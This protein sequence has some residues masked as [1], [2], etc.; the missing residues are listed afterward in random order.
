LCKT[1]VKKLRIVSKFRKLPMSLDFCGA[2]K[3]TSI[4]HKVNDHD[5]KFAMLAYRNLSTLEALYI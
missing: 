5:S 4:T 2:S 3:L 1:T